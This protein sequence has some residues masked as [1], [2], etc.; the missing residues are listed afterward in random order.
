[1][2]MAMGCGSTSSD[3]DLDAWEQEVRI[4]S[5][6]QVGERQY[7]ELGGLLEVREPIRAS[8]GSEDQVIDTAKRNLRRQAAKIDADAVVIVECGRDIRP[9]EESNLPSTGPEVVCHGVAIRWLD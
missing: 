3:P 9:M 5:P 6:S 7:E 8:Y 2:L 1:M 4:L